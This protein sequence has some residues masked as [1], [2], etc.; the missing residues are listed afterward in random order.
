MRKFKGQINGVEYTDIEEFNAAYKRITENGG[1]S[2]NIS[3]SY[4]IE[5][6][7]DPG[8]EEQKQPNYNSGTIQKTDSK[9]VTEDG[10]TADSPFTEKEN[11]AL[12]SSIDVIAEAVEVASKKVQETI[13]LEELPES[14][15]KQ[16]GMTLDGCIQ[17]IRWTVNQLP[18]VLRNTLCESVYSATKEMVDN[19]DSEL[20]DRTYEEEKE[21]SDLVE[22]RVDIEHEMQELDDEINNLESEIEHLGDEWDELDEER[23]GI[24]SQI[25]NS[26]N[27]LKSL[28]RSKKFFRDLIEVFD[29]TRGCLQRTIS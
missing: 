21:N 5:Y 7:S 16:L 10:C 17:R 15:E 18:A 24:V 14:V 29:Y 12:C 6:D 4:E 23:S 26:E 19:I 25:E 28:D 13:D 20:E 1:S 8:T 11:K 22:R 27:R 3:V 2:R 9:K